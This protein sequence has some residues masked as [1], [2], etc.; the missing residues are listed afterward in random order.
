MKEHHFIVDGI[1]I[2]IK[3]PKDLETTEYCPHDNAFI[4]SVKDRLLLAVKNGKKPCA[5]PV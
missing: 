2:N 5:V 1:V 4:L 3:V